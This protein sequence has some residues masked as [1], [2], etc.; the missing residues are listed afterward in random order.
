MRVE[1]LD[2]AIKT[3][4]MSLRNY[5]ITKTRGNGEVDGE[6]IAKLIEDNKETISSYIDRNSNTISEVAY[7]IDFLKQIARKFIREGDS[8]I[9]LIYIIAWFNLKDYAKENMIRDKSIYMN[10]K[11]DIIRKEYLNS[12]KTHM[13]ECIEE[14][15]TYSNTL[16]HMSGNASYGF[17]I[18]DNH[19]IPF[20]LNTV[21]EIS[22]EN[23]KKRWKV[24][25]DKVEQSMV[26]K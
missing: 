22:I 14:T 13:A 2:L 25:E 3:I 15:Y 8:A 5:I 12:T 26:S 19:H 6:F 1:E 21:M 11:L 16:N 17:T 20:I 24:I 7:F 9:F 4:A 18:Y 10:S 23:E